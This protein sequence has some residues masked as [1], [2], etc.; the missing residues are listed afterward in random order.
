MVARG[1][2]FPRVL[3]CLG[4]SAASATLLRHVDVVSILPK[5]HVLRGGV[6]LGLGVGCSCAV[7]AVYRSLRRVKVLIRV[8][9]CLYDISC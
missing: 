9:L 3:A 8:L 1:C 5:D 2:V 6:V 4:V 7:F